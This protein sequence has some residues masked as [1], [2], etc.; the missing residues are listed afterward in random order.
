MRHVAELD[1]P[2]HPATAGNDDHRIAGTSMVTLMMTR[3]DISDDS[4]GGG[5]GGDND[6]NDDGIVFIVNNSYVREDNHDN[7]DDDETCTT[8][9]LFY[10]RCLPHVFQR[11]IA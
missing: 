5:G 10:F 8:K 4:A 3:V 1:L 11:P 6:E 9:S 2:L 7:D